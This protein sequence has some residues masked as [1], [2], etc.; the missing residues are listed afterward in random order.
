MIIVDNTFA[1]MKWQAMLSSSWIVALVLG[2]GNLAIL[3]WVMK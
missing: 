3:Y 2:F 1:R